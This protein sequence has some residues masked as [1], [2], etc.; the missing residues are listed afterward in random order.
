MNPTATSACA[1]VQRCLIIVCAL[2]LLAQQTAVTHA[3]WHAAGGR[4][5]SRVGSLYT[6]GALRDDGR[7]A[8]AQL[9]GF[10][11]AFGQVLGVAGATAA[12]FTVSPDRAGLVGVPDDRCRSVPSVAPHSRSPPVLS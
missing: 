1:T 2:L 9:C 5:D 10:D 12:E 3:V 8:Q 4:L 11:F 6:A 7:P